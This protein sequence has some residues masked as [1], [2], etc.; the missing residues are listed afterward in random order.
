MIV[1]FCE[2]CGYTPTEVKN[3]PVLPWTEALTD[4]GWR[5]V[6]QQP[7]EVALTGLTIGL[8]RSPRHLPPHRWQPLHA[9][10]LEH[11]RQ[12]H[13]LLRWSH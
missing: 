4:W 8:S 12:G 7:W 6:Y 3:A 13:S 11:A 10:R 5:L 2:A 1:D 9:L